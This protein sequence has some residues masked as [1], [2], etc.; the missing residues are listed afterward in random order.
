MRRSILSHRLAGGAILAIVSLCAFP[1]AARRT[2][3]DHAPKLALRITPALAMSPA[4]VRITLEITGGADDYQDYYCPKVEW[5][6]GD[7]TTSDQEPDCDPYVKGKS[8]IQRVYSMSHHYIDTGTL[9][10]RVN[11]LQDKKVVGS[12]AGQVRL[13]VPQ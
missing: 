13:T 7:G 6:W 8:S 5:Q 1:A 3:D 10:V 12:I 4:D 11:L 9:D 2:A